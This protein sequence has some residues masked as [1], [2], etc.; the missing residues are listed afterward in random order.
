MIYIYEFYS[1][2]K[3]VVLLSVTEGDDKPI[4]YPVIFRQCDA[5]LFTKADLLPHVNFNVEKAKSD[6]KALN[7]DSKVFV[8]S[9]LKEEGMNEWL[10]WLNSQLS[11]YQR[12]SLAQLPAR[13][14]ATRE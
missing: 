3:R 6:V 7:A 2:H 13:S 10:D 12:N 5:V 4:K 11:N 8:V 9:A 1:E 14:L